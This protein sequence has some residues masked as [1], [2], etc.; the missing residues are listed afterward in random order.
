MKATYKKYILAF[1]RPSGTS[2]GIM[3]QK[4]TFFII[5]E[6][7]KKFG[8]GECGIL[9]GLS[10]DDVPDYEERLEWT[11]DN[12]GLG[13]DVLW[14]ALMSYPSIQFG[15]EQAFLSQN[16]SD[17]FLL[18]PSEFTQNNNARRK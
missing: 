17:P 7:D 10:V 1:K 14:E 12:I 2:R 8:I 5:L 9:R 16:S 4:E 11:C 13:K 3:T 6:R 18:F 15:V